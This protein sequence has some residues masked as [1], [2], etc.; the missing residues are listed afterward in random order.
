MYAVIIGLNDFPNGDA[1]A[2][3]QFAFARIYQELG[4]D[5]VVICQNRESSEGDYQKIH[6]YSIYRERNSAFEQASFYFGLKKKVLDI[7]GGV[8]R[9]KGE[10]PALL[11]IGEIPY[12]CINSLIRLSRKKNIEIIYNCGEWYSP[13]EFS[14]GR[15]DKTYITNNLI[16]RIIIR[17][18]MKVIAIS[19]Y[20]YD[21]F[22]GK[23]LETIRIPVIM[24]KSDYNNEGHGNKMNIVY[25][26][27]ISGKDEIKQFIWAV[28]ALKDE[29][30]ACLSVNIY[31]ITEDKLGEVCGILT[32]PE[33]VKV[34]G[35]VSRCE[36]VKALD[37]A[38]FSFLLRPANERYA[39]AG[40]PTKVV[41]A[42]THRTAMLCNI[43]SDLGRYLSDKINSVIIKDNSEKEV[44]TALSEIIKM[45]RKTIEEIKR[46]AQKTA[47]EEFY[48]EN[49]IEPLRTFIRK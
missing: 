4:Y 49:Y 33:C 43:S 44:M 6:F 35:R 47:E 16:N 41:E 20:L 23:G 17:K 26:G 13:C 42:M 14:K 29:D 15:F 2:V 9:E 38:D 40:F 5:V 1:G 12:N 21:Y 27:N 39:K 24:E 48:Y 30:R 10:M 45:D 46:N 34:H 3:R 32:L 37:D 28:A 7:L 18:P 8:I 36:V 22:K 11:Q 31:G 19:Q 25:A